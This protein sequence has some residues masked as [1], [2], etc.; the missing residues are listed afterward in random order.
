MGGCLCHDRLRTGYT[1]SCRPF[2]IR[3]RSFRKLK[4]QAITDCQHQFSCVVQSCFD[5]REN[6]G[7]DEDGDDDDDDGDDDD[8]DD[9]DDDDDDDGDDDGDDD[10]DYDDADH[11]VLAHS[12]MRLLSPQEAAV[13]QPPTTR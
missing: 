3:P 8:G 6:D 7:G 1:L 5:L 9:D 2:W 13:P 4:V 11:A 10:D 12:L